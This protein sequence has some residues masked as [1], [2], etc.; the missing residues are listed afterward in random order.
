MTAIHF[1]SRKGA[2]IAKEELYLCSVPGNVQPGLLLSIG[3]G[4]G[5]S[6]P[7]LGRKYGCM[8]V[9]MCGCKDILTP[10]LPYALTPI[11]LKAGGGCMRSL[12]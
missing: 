10:I 6:S 5:V 9:S 3:Y 12:P 2:M 11:L 1:F 8:G 4:L 7:P